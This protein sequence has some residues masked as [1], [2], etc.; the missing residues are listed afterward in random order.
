[1]K[2]KLRSTIGG[3][4]RN[5]RKVFYGG[6]RIGDNHQCYICKKKLRRF[7]PYVGGIKSVPLLLRELRVVG[8]DVENFFCPHCDCTDRERHLSMYF[9]RL[10]LWSKVRGGAV[11]HFAPEVQLSELIK[12]ENPRL[13]VKA[14]LNPRSPD[15]QRIDITDIPYPDN[16]FDVVICNHVL[17]HLPDDAKAFSEISRVIKSDGIAI[18]Q[19]P[20]S[21]LLDTSIFSPLINNDLLR[22][23]YYG[24][25]DH[26]R[27][28]GNDLFKK[29][30]QAGL[31]VNLV[32]HND[33]LKDFDFRYFGVNPDEDL[34]LVTKDASIKFDSRSKS[35]QAH[36]RMSFES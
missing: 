13:Y 29:F 36:S 35:D 17:E 4:L 8:S 33:A 16:S 30:N 23:K 15:T 6:F 24:E 26:Y 11:I 7:I 5:V 19:T 1:M 27:L 14:D 3:Y 9:D 22:K 2:R 10:Q 18:V 32:S 28:Y 31:T 34:I 25:V 20:F 12:K 21:P